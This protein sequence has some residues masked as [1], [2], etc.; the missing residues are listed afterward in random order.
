MA[1]K[2]PN[3][4]ADEKEQI[5]AARAETSRVHDSGMSKWDIKFKDGKSCTM[6]STE[7]RTVE[8]ATE[9]AREKFGD[10]VLCVK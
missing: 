9:A 2:A 5:M 7:C 1:S 6:L 3:L 4:T 8:A 10:K